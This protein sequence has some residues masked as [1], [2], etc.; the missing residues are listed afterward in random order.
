MNNADANEEQ[1]AIDFLL[2]LN[3][4][5]ENNYFL[6]YRYPSPILGA[7]P[8]S[9]ITNAFV[10]K[11][12]LL[13]FTKGEIIA[14]RV[15]NGFSPSLD[16]KK[17]NYDKHLLRINKEAIKRFEIKE[18]TPFGI[19]QG[20]LLTIEADKKYYFQ[21]AKT[22]GDDYSTTNFFHLKKQHFLGL[23]TAESYQ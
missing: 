2:H 15:N 5:P 8:T 14:K 1:S 18:W 19:Y 6:C 13:A 22:T 10:S 4:K 16:W 9:A 12:Y 17:E 11:T 21:V 20:F 7:L 23:A 3:I